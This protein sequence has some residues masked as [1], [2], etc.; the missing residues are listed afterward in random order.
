M[1][2][3][4][5]KL[6]ILFVILFMMGLSASLHLLQEIVSSNIEKDTKKSWKNWFNQI[7][8]HL[9]VI[10]ALECLRKKDHYKVILTMIIWI[11]WLNH[12]QFAQMSF[13][14]KHRHWFI[15]LLYKHFWRTMLHS[16]YLHLNYYC[17]S[18]P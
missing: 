1:R 14:M 7:F 4:V 15:S 11:K 3:L 6:E 18:V 13:K 2:K 17:H 8:I 12:A 9:N 10:Y 5:K 16:K